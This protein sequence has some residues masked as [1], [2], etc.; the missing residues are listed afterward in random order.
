[1]LNC[2]L[3]ETLEIVMCAHIVI[4]IVTLVVYQISDMLIA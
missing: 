4:V 2:N 3:G 1:M